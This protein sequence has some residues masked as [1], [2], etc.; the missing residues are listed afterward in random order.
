MAAGRGDLGAGPDRG[1]D[2]R[3]FGRARAYPARGV[4]CGWVSDGVTLRCG[5]G[6]P[7]SEAQVL[8][9][10]PATQLAPLR[11]FE[12]ASRWRRPRPAW[13]SRVP[14]LASRRRAGGMHARLARRSRARAGRPSFSECAAALP[15]CPP[16]CRPAT[17]SLS[18]QRRSKPPTSPGSNPRTT[19]HRHT[20]T[21][22]HKPRNDAGRRVSARRVMRAGNVFAHA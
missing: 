11:A 2:G 10:M 4:V 3:G 9:L 19:I 6:R 15:F 13:S 18:R 21:S 7:A 1:R 14:W 17:T 16:R 20:S 8:G 5:S 12:V 22:T